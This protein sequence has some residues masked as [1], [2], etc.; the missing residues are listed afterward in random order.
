MSIFN[1]LKYLSL[2]Q[3]QETALTKLDLFLEDSLQVF[4]LK[5]YAGSGKTTIIKIL[6]DC[7]EK[8]NRNYVLM[9]P[10]GRAAKILRDK[11]GKG[12]TIHS[13]IYN[14]DK[15]E[16]VNKD[17]EIEAEH[18]FHYHFPVNQNDLNNN[19]LIIDEASMISAKESKNELFTFGTNNL[20]NDLLTFARVKSNNNKIIFV[21]DPAQLPPI[22]DSNSYA[23][24]SN[25]LNSLG[26]TVVETEMKQVMRQ[27]DNLILENANL[28]RGLL[29]KENRDELALKY[30]NESF[31]KINSSE[32]IEKYIK[33]FPVPEI[34]NGAIISY[35]NSQCYQYNVA[36]RERI[37]PGKKN[38]EVGDLLLI[39][40]NNYHTYGIELFNGDFAKVIGVSS[41][42]ILQSAPIQNKQFNK[43]LNIQLHFRQITIRI[44]SHSEDINCYIIDSLLHSMNRD[45][46]LDEMKALYVNFVMRFKTKQN[47][48][49]ESGRNFYNV[50]SGEFR[51]ELK[52]DP[53]YN[54]L[55]VKFGYAIT[56]HKSQGGEWDKVFVD[57][58][59]RIS[60]KKDPLRW[61]Y[62]AT[63]RGVN[64]VFAFNAPH[65]GKLDG[66][67]FSSIG[68]I[69]TLSNDALNFDNV[70]ISPFHFARQHKCKSAK[71]WEIFEKLE[72]TPYNIIKVESIGTH[73]ERYTISIDDSLIIIQASHK[74]SGHFTDVFKVINPN[75]NNIEKDL[76]ILFNKKVNYIYTYAY[77]PE[78]EYLSELHSMIQE[79]CMELEITITNVQKGKQFYINYYL[80]TD[81]ICSYIQFYYNDKGKLTTAMP[82]SYNCINDNKLNNLILKLT[83]YAS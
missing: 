24:E 41:E 6:I 42:L 83:E 77:E 2:S 75:G 61:C 30:D 7:L 56:C 12:Q 46:S 53:F 43:K 71:Y 19:I 50:G 14:F 58:S 39:N 10:T 35:S 31:I 44:P 76:E 62:T 63:T 28:I 66:F 80:I 65:F 13:S 81:S 34:G 1:H 27:G 11:T 82:K 15:L 52:N 67:K 37:F 70:L 18:S 25:Y 4:L 9:A 64:T 78:I 29:T 17:S 74:N 23:L 26:Y 79:C 3:D 55:K 22:T 48:N 68:H 60:L 36:I 40:N 38:I 47:L 54:A 21:G 72:N 8:E 32:I 73:L 49:K 20:L 33:I 69:G 16:S 5:G 57:Y 59:G 45:L 51:K